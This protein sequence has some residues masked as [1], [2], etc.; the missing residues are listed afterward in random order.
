[1]NINLVNKGKTHNFDIP[2]TATIKYINNIAKNLLEE[3]EKDTFD[4]VYKNKKFSRYSSNT[5]FIDLVDDSSLIYLTIIPSNHHSYS[6]SSTFSS[7]KLTEEINDSEKRKLIYKSLKFNAPIKII[8]KSAKNIDSSFPKNNPKKDDEIPNLIEKLTK[9]IKTKDDNQD[10]G[11]KIND[12]QEKRMKYIKKLLN[13]FDNNENN[14]NEFLSKFYN[15]ISSLSNTNQNNISRNDNQNNIN[16]KSF[17]QIKKNQNQFMSEINNNNSKINKYMEINKNPKNESIDVSKINNENSS[18]IDCFSESH[19]PKNKTNPKNILP[20]LTPSRNK[21]K[22]K[23]FNTEN[24]NIEKLKTNLINKENIFNKTRIDKLKLT[25]IVNKEEKEDKVLK[26]LS[27]SK[28][29]EESSNKINDD[30][31]KNSQELNKDNE[32]NINTDINTTSNKNN[33]ISN[34]VIKNADYRDNKRDF[35]IF[36]RSN[37]KKPLKLISK[38]ND[39]KENY[40]DEVNEKNNEKNEDEKATKIEKEE[41]KNNTNN[42]EQEVKEKSRDNSRFKFCL[43]GKKHNRG[44]LFIRAQNSICVQRDKKRNKIKKKKILA[45]GVDFLY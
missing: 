22:T 3:T 15:Y 8:K 37:S 5:L 7:E 29:E 44:L 11:K 24:N 39:T 2:S 35:S 27:N 1:M 6:I 45:P 36:Y 10:I 40:N 30:I 20:I 32:I 9:K 12:Y 18:S 4:I 21:Y 14:M 13:D 38:D 23:I 43:A 41:N 16:S 26:L 17:D 19:S 33:E 25:K 42:K 31:D 34:Q 28:R